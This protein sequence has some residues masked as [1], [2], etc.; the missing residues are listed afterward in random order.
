MV[1]LWV[2]KPLH[3]SKSRVSDVWRQLPADTAKRPA[4]APCPFTAMS[5]L[6]PG[7]S[8]SFLILAAHFPFLIFDPR[9]SPGKRSFFRLFS[10]FRLHLPG[11][12]V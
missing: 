4:S 1:F 11:D 6:I 8:C 5:A 2:E 7:Q 3:K 10:P 9:F 12:D